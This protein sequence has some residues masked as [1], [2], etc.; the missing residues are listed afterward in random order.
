[1][2]PEIR[3][4]IRNFASRFSS[5]PTTLDLKQ[6]YSVEQLQ[7]DDYVNRGYFGIARALSLGVPAWS[8]ER[9]SVRS[10]LNHSVVWACNR[11]ISETVGFLPLV[12][13]QQSPDGDKRVATEKPLYSLLK[14]APNAEMSSMGFRETRTSHRLLRG[15][16]FALVHRRSG[17]DAS[18]IELEALSPDIIHVDREK[19]GKHRLVYVVHDKSYTVQRGKPQDILHLRGC[20]DDG[21][22]GYPVIE[23][24]RQSVGTAI[25]AERNVARFYANGGRLPYQLKLKQT[26]KDDDTARQFRA[27]WEAIYSE[28]GRAPIIEPWFEYDTIG[29]NLKDSQ[30]LETR[31]FHVAEICRW[32]SLSPHMVGDLS[33]ATNNNIEQLALEF[34]KLTLA[35]HLTSWEQELWR[36]VLTP[37]EQA[38]GYFF[39]H[40]LNA[41]LRGDLPSRMAAYASALQNGEMNI[42]EVRDVEDKNPLPNGAGKAYHLQLNMQTLPG[43]G[44]PLQAQAD[45]AS[46]REPGT[47][48]K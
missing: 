10:A 7:V 23:Y 37:E 40:N 6:I 11:I 44:E 8:G 30:M 38:Q 43:T 1:M 29:L 9:V 13:M 39:R 47:S 17:A 45:P 12:M 41:L 42:D 26:F 35:S 33:K 28:P 27:D 21:V 15:N 31:Q 16:G 48:P 3:G 14:N 34:V 22:R 18:A 25:A 19:H 32:F 46:N 20:G 36:C 24:A 4:A 5:E 2:F